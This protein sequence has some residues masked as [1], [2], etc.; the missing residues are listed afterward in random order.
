MRF[1]FSRYIESGMEVILL[2]NIS[3]QPTA[4]SRVG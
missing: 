3:L 1:Y 4:N 2:Q